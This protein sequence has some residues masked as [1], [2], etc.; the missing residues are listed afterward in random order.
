MS[1][2][3]TLI[4]DY[5]KA[6]VDTVVHNRPPRMANAKRVR[7]I[8]HLVTLERRAMT[9]FRR[10]QGAINREAIEQLIAECPGIMNKEIAQ[11]LNINV[12]TVGRHVRTLRKRWQP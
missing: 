6:E 4:D 7:L 5:V 12:N 1:D 3:L 8:D 11:R 2:L 9:A 10:E